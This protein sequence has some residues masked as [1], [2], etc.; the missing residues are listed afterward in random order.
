MIISRTPYRIS[1]CGGG[2][3]LPIYYENFDYGAVTSTTINKYMYVTLDKRFDN[4]IRL[5]YSRTEIVSNFEDLQ[6]ELI[7]EAMRKTGVTEA[8]EIHTIGEIPGG[9]GMGSSSSLTVGVLHA[10]Y[11]YKGVYVS[12][13]QLGREACEIEIEILKEP[14]GKQDQYIA[15]EG[16]LRHIKFN[17]D[18]SVFSDLI[19]CD[20]Q[21]KKDLEDNLLLFYLNKTRSA[22]S[23]LAEQKQ[24][25]LEKNEF[26]TRM[27]VLSE[28]LRDSLRANNL[29]NFG[30]LLHENWVLK[31]QLAGGISNVEI[32]E[33][34]EIARTKGALGGKVL[35][36]GGGGF[37]LLYVPTE[38]QDDVRESLK[39]LREIPFNFE[40]QGSRIIYVH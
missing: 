2:T 8:L 33:A 11:A 36:A 38:R 21:T 27:R 18:G 13:E 22:N 7:R 16:G 1:F 40:P 28:E 23:I 32:E 14:I 10:L 3:D 26:L 24:K 17:R 29:S 4:S 30:D 19:I 5:S 39:S 20:S 35:G 34:Y 9:T 6:H 15:A 37:L 31:K 25:S 12:A